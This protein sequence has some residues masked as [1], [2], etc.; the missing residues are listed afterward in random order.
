[1]RVILLFWYFLFV[2]LLIYGAYRFSQ[3][4]KRKRQMAAIM[5]LYQ[6][7]GHEGCEELIDFAKYRFFKRIELDDNLQSRRI[8]KEE[9]TVA[10]KQLEVQEITTARKY[11]LSTKEYAQFLRLMM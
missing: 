4:G 2:G 9:Y 3:L 6:K 11:H 5:M 8:T 1:M 7:L 10:I